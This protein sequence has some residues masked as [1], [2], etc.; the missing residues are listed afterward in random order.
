MQGCGPCLFYFSLGRDVSLHCIL[1]LPTL[2]FIEVA[3]NS[4]YRK[5]CCTELNRNFHLA[6]NPLCKILP[7]GATTNKY[8]PGVSTRTV[9]GLGGT[10][11][12]GL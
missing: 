4:L 5:L 8:S 1:I 10:L 9:Q 11:L 2:L 7:D 6:L 3:I 12:V